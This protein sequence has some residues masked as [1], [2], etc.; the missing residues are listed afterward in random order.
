MEDVSSIDTNPVLGEI[1]L[2]TR[3]LIEERVARIN[4]RCL[5]M[6]IHAVKCG[7]KI[8]YPKP[9]RVCRGLK[10]QGAWLKSSSSFGGLELAEV[11]HLAQSL[12]PTPKERAKALSA[13]RRIEK[14]VVNRIDGI[15][16]Y[17]ASLRA[18]QSKWE[19][20]LKSELAMRDLGA[21][22]P[23]KEDDNDPPF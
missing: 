12:T 7:L 11:L 4:A 23:A 10:W 9:V 3:N 21:D 14:W 5:T 22:V 6:H 16:R 15:E 13:M 2:P 8:R 1:D 18:A 20:E 17:A 19:D